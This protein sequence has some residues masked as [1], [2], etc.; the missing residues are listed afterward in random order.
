ML[1]IYDGVHNHIVVSFGP[2]LSFSGLFMYLFSNN[3]RK[4]QHR[5]KDDLVKGLVRIRMSCDNLYFT[6]IGSTVHDCIVSWKGN[7]L[8]TF[9]LL[10]RWTK[11]ILTIIDGHLNRFAPNSFTKFYTS[12]LL[13]CFFSQLSHWVVGDRPLKPAVEHL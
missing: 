5:V 2:F 3:D 11:I 7:T 1:K 8:H 9:C 6:S 10:T 4:S 13:L 12:F